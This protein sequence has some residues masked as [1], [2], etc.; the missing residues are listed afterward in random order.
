MVALTFIVGWGHPGSTPLTGNYLD[1]T[2]VALVH[3]TVSV[4]VLSIDLLFSLSREILPSSG[5]ASSP[6]VARS[7]RFII[8]GHGN[9]TDRGR[10]VYNQVP[11]GPSAQPGRHGGDTISYLGGFEVRRRPIE[12]IAAV[13]RLRPEASGLTS[14]RRDPSNCSRQ[15]VLCPIVP[16]VPWFGLC[17]PG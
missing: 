4:P 16:T 12:D 1:I 8:I 10:N 11:S 5:S 9:L 17:L 6:S 15:V 14:G 3:A 2:L 7:R 13:D